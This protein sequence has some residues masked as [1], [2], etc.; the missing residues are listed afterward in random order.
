MNLCQLSDVPWCRL[1]ITDLL[2][3]KEEWKV[4]VVEKLN[5]HDLSQVTEVNINTDKS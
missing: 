2:S 1:C 4:T 3:K 5:K